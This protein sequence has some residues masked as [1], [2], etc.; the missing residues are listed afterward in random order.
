MVKL[1]GVEEEVPNKT[2]QHEIPE[3]E[4]TEEEQEDQFDSASEEE[5]NLLSTSVSNVTSLD[6]ESLFLVGCSSRPIN[7]D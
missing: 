7:Q 4:S 3:V 6:K 2:S 1:S 5:D